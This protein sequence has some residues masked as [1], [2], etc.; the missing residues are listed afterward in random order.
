MDRRKVELLF[1]KV[2]V[3]MDPDDEGDR[4]SLL[5]DQWLED[6]DGGLAEV[7]PA[8]YEVLANQVADEDPPEVWRTARR[9]L[10]LGLERREVL[11][12]LAMALSAEIQRVVSTDEPSDPARYAASLARLPV[13]TRVEVSEVLEDLV[14]RRQ[15]IEVE[16]LMSLA[17]ERLGLPAGE[18]PFETLVDSVLDR[19]IDTDGA[20]AI[21]AGDRIVHRASILEDVV[22]THRLPEAER[23][24][25][26]LELSGDLPGM[27]WFDPIESDLGELHVDLGERGPAAWHGPDGWLARFAADSLLA[28]RVEGARVDVSELRDDLVPDPDLVTRIRS[29]YDAE[30]EEPGTPVDAEDVLLGVLADDRA[31]GRGPAFA[32]PQAPLSD[33]F[34]AAGLELRGNDLAHDEAI[35]ENGRRAAR[36]GRVAH[37][38]EEG[39][40]ILAALRILDVADDDAQFDPSV[41]RGALVDLRSPRMF[42]VVLDEVLGFEDDPEAVTSLGRFAE[43]LV[44]AAGKPREV[45][46]ARVTAAVA[47]ERRGD[48]RAAYEH[49]R[50]AVGADPDWDLGVDRL[51]WCLSDRGDAAEAARLWRSLGVG[52][53][54]NQ[55]LREVEPFAQH[56]EPKLG[57]NDPC[58]CGSGRKFKVCHLGRPALVP[59]P[60][61]VG[62]LCR[63]AAAY[64]ERRG[65]PAL[66]DVFQLALTRAGPDG[67]VDDIRRAL[68]DALVVDVAL[69]ELGWFERFLAERGALLPDDEALLA[70]SWTVVERTVY[71]VTEARPGVGM[72]LTDLRSADH[73]EVRE[74]TFSRRARPGML[75]C[76]RA[77]P[78]GESHQLVG[79]VLSVPPGREGPLLDVLDRGDPFEL[80]DFVGSLERPPVVTTREGEAVVAC[81]AVIE[82][83]DGYSA[84]AVL[85]VRFQREDGDTWLDTH[86]LE[87]DDSVIRATLRL[88]GNTLLVEAISEERLDRTVAVVTGAIDGARLVSDERRPVRTERL[89]AR[90]RPSSVPSPDIDLDDPSVRTAMEEIVDRMERRWCDEPVPALAGLT[91]R[92][93]AAD[94]TRRENL[95]RLLSTFDDLAGRV[96]TAGSGTLTMRPDRLRMLLG[97]DT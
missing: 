67:E 23:A 74:R 5:R 96:G 76:G 89:R 72:S 45:S 83:P 92:Q 32:T 65:G 18:E 62:W 53:E 81:E 68:D 22:L 6:E 34:A 93:A 37:R 42:E 61:R 87:R 84:R 82:V 44:A 94:P 28:V 60:D 17:M 91:P 77:V 35:W 27:A 3:G 50:M 36:A 70:A 58:W 80:M 39:D 20:L 40:D 31:A 10:D 71:E 7:R 51:A 86:T 41:L 95:E 19:A 8:V 75:I 66:Q 97:L 2:P 15:P 12:N 79:G 38:L 90:T 1:G 88:D 14:R 85:D 64:L 48:P 57:R 26:L 21:L 46:V 4:E 63:K 56:S 52:P 78:D 9:L 73:M 33:L 16:E 29:V 54:E 43:R 11:R 47:A 25:D 13:P 55:N 30:V 24:S 59:L 49:L 69:H